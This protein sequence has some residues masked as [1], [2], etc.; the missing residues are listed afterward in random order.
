[1]ANVLVPLAHGCEE[2]E[3]ITIIDLLRR[4]GIKVV[5]AS[6]TDEPVQCSRQTVI[7]ADTT[8][9]QVM[10]E[11]FD[12]MVLP[13]GLPGA[14]NLNADTRIHDLLSRL[15]QQGKMT[16]AICAA[17]RVLLDHGLLAGK[18]ATAYPGSLANHD[19]SNTDLQDTAVEIAG[20]VITSRG[21][22][23]AMDFSLVLIEL[24]K[25]RESRDAVEQGLVR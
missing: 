2:L 5:T 16:A 14:D 22:G 9:D 21:P 10:Q 25:G 11:D 18:K 17:P 12:L 15:N 24:L 13:G 1:M 3:A 4:A 20:N 6:L 19:T 8:L 23:T 7:V